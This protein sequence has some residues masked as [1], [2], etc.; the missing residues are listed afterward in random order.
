MLTIYLMQLLLA[1]FVI[2]GSIAL[3]DYHK[4][5]KHFNIKYNGEIWVVRDSKGRFVKIT[6][7]Y[8]DVCKLGASL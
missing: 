6:N 4:A 8:W 2:V 1:A 5:K 7:N 3:Y